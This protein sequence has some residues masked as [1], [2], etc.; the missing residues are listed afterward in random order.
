[1]ETVH[2]QLPDE[3]GVIIV[4]EKFRDKRPCKLIFVQDDEGIAI[5]GPADQFGIFGLVKETKKQL[6]RLK[7]ICGGRAGIEEV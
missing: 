6:E 4:F 3:R 7:P 2:I 1:M 5:F